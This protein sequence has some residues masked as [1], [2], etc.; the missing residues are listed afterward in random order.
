MEEADIDR[1]SLLWPENQRL[2][3]DYA[4]NIAPIMVW[5]HSE[6]NSYKRLVAPLAES[7]KS[8]RL[9][10]LSIAAAHAAGARGGDSDFSRSAYENA[11]LL[12]TERVREMAN[13]ELNSPPTQSS[14]GV[15]TH[16]G[17]LAAALILSNHSLFGT[18]LRLCGIHRKAVR[19]LIATIRTSMAVS[20]SEL[21]SFL[22][23]Q[24]AIYD[25]LVCTTIFDREN[26]KGAIL[27]IYEEGSLMFGRYLHV[28]HDI[29]KCSLTKESVHGGTTLSQ[30]AD[31]EDQLE[32]AQSDTLLA[33]APILVSCGDHTK[34]DFIRITRL[35]HHAGV[36]Y[37]C[38]RLCIDENSWLE[39]YHTSK[40]FRLFAQFHDLNVALH[41]LAWPVFIAGICS[42]PHVE[43][44]RTVSELTTTLNGGAGYGHYEG[45]SEFHEELW[46][47]NHHDWIKLAKEWEERGRQV[48]PV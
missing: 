3:D 37:A 41:N 7:Q 30:I 34:D 26:I 27:P 22:S 13:G 12:I 32:L 46:H 14:S 23:N 4:N 28:L 11:L 35:Y 31:F 48:I 16:E 6:H 36:L 44:M 17:I 2:I 38:R 47:S 21:F 25:I 39:S 24:A 19:I 9:A 5:L 15:D 33:A 45:I 29:T 10:I 20:G 18:D 43:R 1:F 40:L 42:W 8:L